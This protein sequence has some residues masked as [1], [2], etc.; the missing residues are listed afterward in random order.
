MTLTEKKT[1]ALKEKPLAVTIY[2]PQNLRA[3]S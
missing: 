2:L 3:F 1:E